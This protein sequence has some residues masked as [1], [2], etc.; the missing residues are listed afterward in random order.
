MNYENKNILID[1]F[2]VYKRKVTKTNYLPKG[3]L[4]TIYDPKIPPKSGK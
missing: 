1:N 3:D 2:Y 4:Y